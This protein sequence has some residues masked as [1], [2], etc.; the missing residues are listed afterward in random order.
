MDSKKENAQIITSILG[1]IGESTEDEITSINAAINSQDVNDS[2]LEV[3]EILNQGVGYGFFQRNGKSYSLGNRYET[4]GGQRK[5][6][7]NKNS[8]KV[9]K[10]KRLR[11]EA[12]RVEQKL[13]IQSVPKMKAKPARSNCTIDAGQQMETETS[14][15]RGIEQSR[16]RRICFVEEWGGRMDEVGEE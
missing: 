14:V 5:P 10:W 4:D 8:I 15:V 1:W 16:P 6:K 3:R 9:D 12:R 13:S 7:K 2:R 11:K